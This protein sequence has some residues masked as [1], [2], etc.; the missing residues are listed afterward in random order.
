MRVT[1]GT[2]IVYDSPE[3][4]KKLFGLFDEEKRKATLRRDDW[5]LVQKLHLSNDVLN[6]INTY[7]DYIK[8]A[9]ELIK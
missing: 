2:L 4:L 1:L 7:E 9:K 3:A 5:V 6:T 8:V